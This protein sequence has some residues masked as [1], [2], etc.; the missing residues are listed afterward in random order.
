MQ[1]S[2]KAMMP[3]HDNTKCNEEQMEKKGRKRQYEKGKLSCTG[4]AD[5]AG[6]EG[7]G[8]G[9]RESERER[10]REQGRVPMQIALHRDFAFYFEL[11]FVTYT[12]LWYDCLLEF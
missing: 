1:G 12:V 9:E 6:G 2:V 10:E 3:R 8:G 5:D 4:S 7:G 11:D